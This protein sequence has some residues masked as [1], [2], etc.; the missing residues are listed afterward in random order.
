[1]NERVQLYS[2]DETGDL[3]D[4]L[5]SLLDY[6][7]QIAGIA[8]IAV[9]ITAVVVFSK[10]PIYRATSSIHI[11][12]NQNN[13]LNVQGA[14]DTGAGSQGYY[15]TQV[16]VLASREL[17][18]KAVEQ[19]DWEKYPEFL[20]QATPE[21]GWM[22]RLGEYLPFIAEYT[23]EGDEPVPLPDEAAQ[24]RYLVDTFM[25]ATKIE[26]VATTQIVKIHFLSKN[27][28]LA[29]DGANA[30]A[31]V[32]IESGFEAQLEAT[33]RATEWM[34]ER[35]Q[36]IRDSLAASESDLQEFRESQD[37][38]NIRG[39]RGVLE[40]E[41]SDNMQRL[42]EAQSRQSSLENTYEKIQRVGSS[43][44]GLEQIPGLLEKE[45]VEST[46]KSYLVAQE[47]ISKLRSRYGPK[48]PK[49][50]EAKA[51]L[52][53]ARAAFE[54]ELRNAAD[55]IRSQYQIATDNVRA[56]SKAVDN[57]REALLKLDR[58]EYQLNV[59]QRETETNSE[60]YDTILT[61]FKETDMAGDFQTLKA[62]IVDPAILPTRAYLPNKRRA[63]M[64][65]GF[66]GLL[67]GIGLALIRHHLDNSI[68]TGDELESIAGAPVFA[69]VPS[70]GGAVFGKAVSR[71]IAEKPR[72]VF[73]EGVRTIRTGVV[74]S[75]LDQKK[76]RLLITSALEQEG[77]SCLA[78]N[79]AIAFGQM[80]RVLLVDC[81]MRRPT[82]CRYMKVK[83]GSQHGLS[84]L[85]QGRTEPAKAVHH[86]A[87][88]VDLLPVGELPS[89]PGAVLTSQRFRQVLEELSAD[90]DRVIIDSAPCQP[91]SDTLLLAKH[92][93][94]V[95]FVV[96]YDSTSIKVVQTALRRLRQ[97]KAPILG[98]VLNRVDHKKALKNGDSYYYG[99][100]YS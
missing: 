57:T 26:P 55:N 38:V 84:A 12:P 1:M 63:L 71:Y 79:L 75:D 21:P 23:A 43:V 13:V 19:I 68:R 61:R 92:V 29:K 82:L 77:K 30:L 25:R 74:L 41:L 45:L 54:T 70:V 9:L 6:K 20:P 34:N 47:N 72:S 2:S 22:S 10:E 67:A 81:D 37:V 90:Y 62:H 76:K 46:K 56:L 80:E 94:G 49:M 83:S 52:E 44:Y 91:V 32:Y 17:A 99:Y 85:L 93:D 24:K 69:S 28:Q 40:E 36:G 39:G 53:E 11:E 86:V 50:I 58:K 87:P 98:A 48:H 100:Y 60:L 4:Q 7:F 97:S 96:R 88:N 5:R 15:A 42:R 31:D 66:F 27:P 18:R 89:G 14:Y 8:L 95:I 78:T 73:S 35:L 65:A 64:M 33:R 3:F 59:L 16:T 51:R